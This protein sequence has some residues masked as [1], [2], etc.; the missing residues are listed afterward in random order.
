M[1]DF[2]YEPIRKDCATNES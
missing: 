1:L 2:H